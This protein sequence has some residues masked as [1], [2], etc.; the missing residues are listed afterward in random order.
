MHLRQAFILA[1]ISPLLMSYCS[2]FCGM[3]IKPIKLWT[4]FCCCPST[5][6][7]PIH[8]RT[9]EEQGAS[10]QKR[11]D[12]MIDISH[13]RPDPGEPYGHYQRRVMN[14]LELQQQDLQTLTVAIDEKNS[15]IANFEEQLGQIKTRQADLRLA[16]TTIN[17]EYANA[18]E[19]TAPL[20]AYTVRAGDTLQKISYRRFGSHAAW[21]SLFRFNRERLPDG[22][23]LIEKG[24]TLLIPRHSPGVK[25]PRA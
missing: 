23:N 17:D 5:S 12:T 20:S 25:A 7:C 19:S 16:L 14:T 8:R 15:N 9:L 2:N 3:N 13:F 22:P 6:E 10:Y 1:L 11:D 21:L 4:P 24:Q 18:K